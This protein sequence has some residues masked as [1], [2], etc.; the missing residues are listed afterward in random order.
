MAESQMTFTALMALL[1]LQVISPVESGTT[2]TANPL[3]ALPLPPGI[4]GF[5]A[6]PGPPTTTTVGPVPTTTTTA[7]PVPTTTTTV[8]PVPTTTTTV[9]PLP[10]ATTTVGAV[11]GGWVSDDTNSTDVELA[12]EFAVSQIQIE[13]NSLYTLILLKVL[14]AQSQVVAGIN[15][16]MTLRVGTTNS[17]AGQPPS[18]CRRITHIQQCRVTVWYQAWRKPNTMILTAYTCTPAFPMTRAP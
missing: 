16:Q 7:G 1:V 2:T 9:G 8:G 5:P 17:L 11:P 15:Y 14:T 13:T 6:F 4:G 18:S 12:A 10:A 3:A